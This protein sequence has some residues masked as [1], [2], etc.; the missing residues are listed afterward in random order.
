[1]GSID[2]RI[3]KNTFYDPM[4]G[5]HL[6]MGYTKHGYAI[7]SVGPRKFVS[8]HRFIWEKVYGEIPK[9]LC[10][11]HLCRVR[12]CLNPAHME[13]VTPEENTRRGI[14]GKS[15]RERQKS[16]THCIRGHDLKNAYVSANGRRQC[17][18]C[19]YLRDNLEGRRLPTKTHCINGHELNEENTYTNPRTGWKRC[20][21]CHSASNCKE[22]N[23][24]EIPY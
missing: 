16:K 2:D 23:R 9:H 22:R 8:L 7:S 19:S 24:V 20:R 12:N 15:A 1:M 14:A 3:E 6:W 13:L 10:I 4:S 18:E 21:K 17:R 11:D 5:C